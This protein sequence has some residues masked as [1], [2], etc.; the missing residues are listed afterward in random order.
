VIESFKNKKSNIIFF[1]LPRPFLQKI[2]LCYFNKKHCQDYCTKLTNLKDIKKKNS[3]INFL[4]TTFKH[5]E[6]FKQF[7]G[8]ISF[9]LFYYAEKY[10]EEVCKNLN[11][12]Y[13][14]LHKE[15]AFTPSEEK[16][17]PE[18][19][20][21][22]NNKSLSYKISVYTESQ[23]KI[24]IKS[25]I[26][27]KNQI[28]VVGTPRSDY[29]FR[30]R[31]AAPKEKV[32]VFYLIEFNRFTFISGPKKKSWN[33]LYNQTLRYLYNFAKINPNIQIILKGKTGVHNKNQSNLNNLPQNCRFIDGGSGHSLLNNASVVIA[34]NSTIVFE[35][36]ASNRNLIIPNFN[37]ENKIYKNILHKIDNKVHF[38][39]SEIQFYKKIKFYLDL[40]YKNKKLFMSDIKTL[41]HYLGN[42]DSTAGN[43]VK[44]FLEKTIR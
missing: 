1:L 36:I 24:L 12:K 21:K 28:A 3:Y 29:A 32:I 8:F 22:F 19:Y 10:F 15:S 40:N 11:K 14:I 9:N 6:N 18:I 17:A 41:K 5:I 7:D 35:A 4:T 16:R 43:K 31:K 37:N 42:T 33:K 26:A 20:K 38:V 34:F 13:I 39:N 25:K 30:L 23:K 2:F 44:K 27:H